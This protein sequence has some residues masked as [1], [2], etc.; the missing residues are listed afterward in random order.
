MQRAAAAWRMPL[1]APQ[2]VIVRSAIPS[3]ASRTGGLTPEARLPAVSIRLP[4]SV[5]LASLGSRK[6]VGVVL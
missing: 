2:F 4:P 3:T 1:M 6:R 5:L